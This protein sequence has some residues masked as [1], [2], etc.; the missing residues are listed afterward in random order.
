MF[1]DVSDKPDDAAK[2]ANLTQ[3]RARLHRDR[4]AGIMHA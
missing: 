4:N 1:Y 2:E 3:R